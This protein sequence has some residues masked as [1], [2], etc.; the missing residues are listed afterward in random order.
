MKNLTLKKKK[1]NFAKQNLQ[2]VW[3][4]LHPLFLD[5]LNRPIHSLSELEKWMQNRSELEA[6]IEEDAAWRYIRMTCNTAD[7]KLLRDFQYFATEIEPKIAPIN[8]QLNK[9]LIDSPYAK[10]L[11]S[12]KYFIYLRSVQKSLDLFREE[13]IPLQTKIQ[14][15]QQKYQSITGSMSVFLNE[16]EYTLE[17]AAV[18]LKDIDRYIRE[19]TW[20][21]ITTRRLEDKTKLNELFNQLIILRHQVANNADFNN[22][23]DY[24]FEAMGRFDYS[25]EDCYQ[26]HDAI[27]KTV[28][29]ILSLEAKRRKEK[30]GL[31]SLKPWDMD[32]DPSGHAPLKPFIDGED[33]IQKTQLCFQKLD[34]Y[35]GERIEIMKANNLFDLESRK[36]KAPGGYNYPLSESGAP[37]IFMN[38][39]NTFR[40]L[41]TMVHEGGHALHT[42]I[43]ADLE[44]NDFKHLPSEVAELASMSM[45]LISMSHWNIFFDNEEDLK[46]A[47]RDQLVDV[48]KTLPWVATVD[49]FQHWIYTHP[50]HT[51]LEREQEWK[52]IF[53]RFGH[54][55][56]N[57]DEH[58]DALKNLWQ[59]QLHIFEVPF[60]YIEYGMA[61]LGAIA[62]W[63]NYIE[64]P[65]KGLNNYLN[66]LKLGYTKTIPEIYQTAGITFKFNKEYVKEL[67]DFVK[68]ELDKLN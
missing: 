58:S 36:G 52:K 43:S 9:K 2:I 16:K 27:E 22:F 26:F 29:P 33:L 62:I 21:A 17:Q 41:T 4:E 12:N 51:D 67:V 30:L 42:F 3:E 68:M 11:D 25:P 31:E 56:A 23:R 40:D 53:I 57:W 50:N 35:I 47:K 64:N 10:E 48:L 66:A 7:E 6:I 37:F 38:S 44:L 20:T 61:Q 19:T 28:V 49:Q 5:L 63:K 32:V 54:S 14:L 8:N 45:E 15:E 65:E 46:R 55:F 39:A 59:K 60:Y 34:N 13:N 18:F 1:R 24:M